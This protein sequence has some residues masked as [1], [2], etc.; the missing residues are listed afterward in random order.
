M[1]QNHSS[2]FFN[3]FILHPNHCPLLITLSQ[4]PSQYSHSHSP[5]RAWRPQTPILPTWHIKSLQGQTH[6]LPLRPV[7]Q[8]IKKNISHRQATTCGMATASVV[9]DPHEKVISVEGGLEPTLLCSLVSDLVSR[10]S[11]GPGQLILLV[12]F[13]WSSYSL[14]G[15]KSFFLIL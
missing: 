13:L 8:P 15:T 6:P 12:I 14:W 9:W 3:L 7:R 5:M 1:S 10:N 2:F 4:N 11:K